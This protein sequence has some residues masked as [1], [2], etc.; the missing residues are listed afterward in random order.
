[1]ATAGPGAGAGAGAGP[2]RSPGAGAGPDAGAGAG[3]GPGT[4]KAAKGA[5]A[6]AGAGGGAMAGAKAGAGAFQVQKCQVTRPA[7]GEFVWV[8]GLQKAPELQ[9]LLTKR[10]H[11]DTWCE[12]GQSHQQL[13]TSL[14]SMLCNKVKTSRANIE[15]F[16]NH[17]DVKRKK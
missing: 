12:H 9:S 11:C 5:K 7:G 16:T 10:W 15:E 13:S 1:M 2:N 3:A 8:K 4:G 6:K 14:C 17:Q